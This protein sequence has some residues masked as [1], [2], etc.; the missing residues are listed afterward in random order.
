MKIIRPKPTNN[1]QE[2]ILESKEYKKLESKY[3]ELVS[4]IK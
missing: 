4:A 1:N 3:L 2:N